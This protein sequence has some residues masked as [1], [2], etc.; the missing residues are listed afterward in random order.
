MRKLPVAERIFR[1]AATAARLSAAVAELAADSC[2]ASAAR[3]GS[4]GTGGCCTE[5]R[6]SGKRMLPREAPEKSRPRVGEGDSSVS[7]LSRAGSL[8]V[9]GAESETASPQDHSGIDGFSVATGLGCIP[10]RGCADGGMTESR[11]TARAIAAALVAAQSSAA[12]SS[13]CVELKAG[14]ASPRGCSCSN[15][16]VLCCVD[17]FGA[18]ACSVAD[19]RG[20]LVS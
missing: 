12:T 5:E 16:P 3:E 8:V 13:A 19:A 2:S 17:R 14:S 18:C 6:A 1:A 7:K 10:V 9:A 11:A 4:S 15:L 20:G